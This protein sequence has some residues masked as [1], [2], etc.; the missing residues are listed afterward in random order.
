MNALAVGRLFGTA[1]LHTLPAERLSAVYAH[2][3]KEARALEQ[4]G[5][6]HRIAHGY[7]CSIPPDQDPS[8]WRPSTEGAAIGVATAMHGDRV[9]ILTGLSA[10]RSHSAIPRAITTAFVAVPTPGR[11]PL[12]FLDREGEIR[13]VHRRVHEL[14]AVLVTTDLGPALATSPEQTVLDLERLDP[15]NDDPDH[16]EAIAALWRR[17][18]PDVLD[19]IAHRQRMRAT[20]SRL[21]AAR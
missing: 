1:P 16:S 15:R 12:R 3:R 9:P 14:D 4:R 20:L 2:P 5:V 18:D 8:T 6:L 21:R 17:C 13:F 11:R 7:Y 19:D 10:A